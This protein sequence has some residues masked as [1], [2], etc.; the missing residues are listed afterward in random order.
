MGGNLSQ[1]LPRRQG[2]TWDRDGISNLLEAL[3]SLKQFS[4]PNLP[5]PVPSMPGMEMPPAGGG[6]GA[7]KAEP[8][9]QAGTQSL[10]HGPKPDWVTHGQVMASLL[11]SA[12]CQLLLT[13]TSLFFCSESLRRPQGTCY[14]V[15][16]TYAMSDS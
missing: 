15:A 2:R 12:H 14:P 4:F 1:E 6:G 9:L 16:R 11:P 5:E 13:L 7:A 3:C 8:W 10:G